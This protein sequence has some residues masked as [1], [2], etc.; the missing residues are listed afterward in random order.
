VEILSEAAV[1][2]MGQVQ[3]YGGGS[4][5]DKQKYPESMAVTERW[6]SIDTER[7]RDV[8]QLAL[9]NAELLKLLAVFYPDDTAILR[10]VAG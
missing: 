3:S 9:M 7:V 8:V 2:S 6:K 10:S 4:S 1:H 5:F